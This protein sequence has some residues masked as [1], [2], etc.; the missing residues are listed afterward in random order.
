MLSKILAG[1]GKAANLVYIEDVF[2]TYLYTGN[3]AAQTIP[4]GIA[5]G[6][7]SGGSVYFGGTGYLQTP[8]ALLSSSSSFT[9][10]C[11][12][13]WNST[14]S[15]TDM[16]M[17]TSQYASGGAGRFLFGSQSGAL[18]LRVNGGT[19]YLTTSVSTGIWYHIAWTFDGTTHRLFKDGVLSDSST[20]VPSLYTGANT[21]LGGQSDTLL[22]GY[23]LNGFISN[24]RILSG[25]ALYTSGFTPPT[26]PLTAIT[27]TSLLT[28][29]TP[30]TV[31]DYSTNAY[32]ITVNGNAI[33]QNGGGPFTD[34]TANKGGLVWL[35]GRSGATDHALYDT[36]R[37]ATFDLVSNST[38]AQT[39]Q[40]TGL[41]AFNSNGF[42]IGALAKLNT[43][44]A[45]YTSWTFREQDRFFDVRT[46]SHT[47]GTA[48]VVDLSNLGTL[49]M[50]IYRDTG[51]SNW[52]VW[53]RSLTGTNKLLLNTTDAQALL[54]TFTVSGTTLTIGT[55]ATTGTKL[56]YAFAHNA[57]GFGL[58]GSDNVISCGAFTTD[59]SGNATVTLGYEPQWL[60]FKSSTD[61]T[62]NWTIRD[63]VRGLNAT[64][65]GASLQ[66]NT[67]S[68]ETTPAA[69]GA[70]V[71]S[72]GF[73]M[74]AGG[75]SSTYIYM[76]IRRG[77][78]KTPTVGTSVLGLNARTGT[79][80]ATTVTGGAGVT[81][82]AIIKNRGSAI[83]WLWGSRLTGTGYIASNSNAAEVAAGATIL[84]T[85]PWDVMDGVKVGTT[86]TITNASAATFINYL[87]RRAPGFFD[88]VCDTGTASQHTINHGLGVVPELI[89]RKK[90]NSATNSDWVV[91]HTLFAGT[92]DYLYLNATDA[93]ASNATFWTATSP[94]SSVF[95]VGTGS[96]VN[97]LN[98]TYITFLFASVTGVSK[99]GS[100]TGDGTS[101]RVINC[102]F[103]GGARFVMIKKTNALGNWFI[104]DT[105][106]G[107][108]SGNDPR[109][110]PN[111]TAAEV[112]TV[113]DI[114]PDASGFIV[115][116]AAAQINSSGDSYIF[117]AIA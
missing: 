10:E 68:A 89:I 17:L 99:I 111:S 25:T 6:D 54:P 108:V 12:A 20:T 102:G 8:S 113:D 81:D 11:W 39:T 83:G 38:A 51:T 80:A 18:V 29:K 67:T 52:F 63:N 32:T 74:N 101:G 49:G 70:K 97:N 110:V 50:I 59:G 75:S 27:N 88:I 86:S 57:G 71:T 4:N 5:I 40:A 87:L 22:S 58:T 95:T 65:N 66:P 24:A 73:T 16:G 56:I 84:Q 19:V 43:N 44:A 34:P 64:D 1:A 9:F 85:N 35:K 114:D 116:S 78:M 76:T 82:L 62:N 28:C 42:S 109:L 96:R 31:L 72:T 15:S 33:A 115:N 92:S 41:T 36:V 77:P 90:R 55:A 61:A 26:A 117:L 69:I 91:W 106:R 23:K 94:T 53:H 2:S 14:G 7:D 103:T 47:N 13:Y 60:L 98:D 45:T 37:G 93:V 48:T 112:T 105:A 104:W 21:S 100:Y 107:I 79:G 30:N 3:G 46:V